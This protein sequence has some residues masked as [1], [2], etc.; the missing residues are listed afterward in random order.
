VICAS[1][2]AASVTGR[3]LSSDV[4][5]APDSAF[6]GAAAGTSEAAAAF[7]PPAKAARHLPKILMLRACLP[8]LV[9]AWRKV[10]RVG[11]DVFGTTGYLDAFLDQGLAL[12]RASVA[13]PVVDLIPQEDRSVAPVPCLREL[14]A[15]G[16]GVAGATAGAL[17]REGVL[18]VRSGRQSR[19]SGVHGHVLH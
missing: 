12:E 7:L 8:A 6:T 14:L 11:K 2:F 18:T 3:P 4:D 1:T 17:S 13:S 16:R 19:G 9:T 10:G 5:L 15:I